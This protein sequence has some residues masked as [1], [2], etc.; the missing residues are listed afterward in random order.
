M[1]SPDRRDNPATDSGATDSGAT[2]RPAFDTESFDR[3]AARIRRLG[4]VVCRMDCRPATVP[5]TGGR[6]IVMVANHRS[7]ADVFV[8]IDALGRFGLPTRCLVRS[9][10]FER[11]GMGRWLRAVGCIPA[12]DGRRG[13]VET[14]L[15][16]L[17]GGGSVAIMAEGRITPPDERDELGLGPFRPGFA[18][19]ARTA[20][21]AILPIAI[22]GSDDIWPS[23]AGLPR[24]PWRGR[25]TVR[26]ELLD[27]ILCDDRGD[28]EIVGATRAAIGRGLALSPAGA[29]R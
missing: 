8:A 7:L 16:T 2:D 25:P 3:W 18:Q 10:Y 15:A 14:A 19:I 17:A 11:P 9:A 26:V 6:P 21:A 1:T 5:D 28:E 23:R 4:R 27:P 12:G 22:E 24:I 29:A 13:S 20:G